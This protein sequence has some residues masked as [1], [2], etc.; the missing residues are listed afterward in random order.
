MRHNPKCLIYA[1][2]LPHLLQRLYSLTGNRF[3]FF[4]LAI[5]DA[6]AKPTSHRYRSL[7]SLCVSEV[8]ES[9]ETIAL[10]MPIFMTT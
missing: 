1:R 3:G 2:G 5:L 8:F 6:L 4:Q 7:H 9:V 10:L